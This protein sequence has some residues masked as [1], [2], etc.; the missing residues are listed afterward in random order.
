MDTRVPPFCMD[1]AKEAEFRRQGYDPV[2][3]E[4][5]F[6]RVLSDAHYALPDPPA[7]LD[8]R[9]FSLLPRD[10]VDRVSSLPDAL[11]GNIVSRLPI[12]EAA[13]TAALA[14]RWRGVWRS[15]PLVLVD[16]HILPAGTVVGRANARR[17]TSVVSRV[18]DAHPG[19]LRC[20][21]LTSSY[22]GEFYGLLTRWLQTLAAKGIQ[23]LVLFNRPLPLDL[24][25]PAT[26]LGMTTLT[27]LYL[28]MW[29]FPDMA[30]VPRATC[31]PNLRELG[32]ISVYM[33]SRALDFILDRSPVLET[34]CVGGNM[35]T[36]PLRLVSQSLRC[37]HI[38]A[39]SF[40]EIVV[41]DA[42]RL[43]RL[44]YSGGWSLDGACTKLKIGHAPKLHL[45]GYL[46]AGNHLLEVGKTVVKASPSTM[47]P[48]VRILA[49]EVLFRV[50]NDVKMIP[51]VLRC[52]PNVETLHIMSGKTDQPS[53]KVNLKFWYECGTIECIRSCIKRL[54]FHDFQGDRSELVFLKFFL[55][56][57]LVLKEVVIV[58]AKENLT[59]M[60]DISSKVV[61]LVS[62]KR[63]SAGSSIRVTRCSN[64]Q[65]DNMRS[66]KRSSDFSLGDPFMN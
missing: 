33:E 10:G 39:C 36:T 6:D 11:L 66:N 30:G 19:P 64:P 8:A 15:A 25:L 46:H 13:R 24:V 12:K 20:V 28:G 34:L 60:E 2:E 52:F 4:A 49:L 44:I 61:P 51:T 9:L 43:E 38:T 29:K 53:G 16:S 41:V 63:A 32:F 59:S 18:L 54:V 48:S 50:R 7:S 3:L 14:R 21:H 23:E 31:F 55:G 45:L 35:F 5:H 57:A 58:L 22:M 65:G 27:R 56:S 37:V 17:V 62:M 26:F 42:P 47:L 40:E 1:L